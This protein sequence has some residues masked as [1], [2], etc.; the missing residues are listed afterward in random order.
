MKL[1]DKLK[2]I[3]YFRNKLQLT[4]KL[5]PTFGTLLVKLEKSGRW[6]HQQEEMLNKIPVLLTPI[7]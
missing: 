3:K 6:N 5:Y 7:C 4:K 1:F 2:A